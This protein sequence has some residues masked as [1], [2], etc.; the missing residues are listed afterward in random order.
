MPTTLRQLCYVSVFPKQGL[1]AV[2]DDGAAGD[3]TN[4]GILIVHHRYKILGRGPLHQI[5]H[6]GGDSD[7]HIVL[8]VGDFHN[9]V[10]LR[11]TQIHLTDIF[12]SPQEVAFG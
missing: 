12:H 5:L 2:F 4:E 11:L 9:S 10:A 3:N 6:G 8:S 7:G 1:L